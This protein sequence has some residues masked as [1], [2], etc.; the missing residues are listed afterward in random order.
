M[1]ASPSSTEALSASGVEVVCAANGIAQK[2]E[3]AKRMAVENRMSV[4]LKCLL[5]DEGAL[6][7]VCDRRVLLGWQSGETLVTV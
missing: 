6:S 1:I 7:S 5:D 2:A 3:P 4:S